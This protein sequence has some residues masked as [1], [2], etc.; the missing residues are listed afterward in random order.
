M[1]ASANILI[2]GC[3][4]MFGSVTAKELKEH[5]SD[6]LSRVQYGGERGYEQA[7]QART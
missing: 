5:A 6:V 4:G 1:T 7:H 2:L 3:R